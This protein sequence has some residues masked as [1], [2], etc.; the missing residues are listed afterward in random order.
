MDMLGNTKMREAILRYYQESG[1]SDA[2]CRAIKDSKDDEDVTDNGHMGHFFN[3]FF[4][5]KGYV[6]IWCVCVCVCVCVVCVCVCVC[7]ACGVVCV[8]EV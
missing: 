2:V 7:S 8:C 1:D 5:K 3:A 6:T 4:G